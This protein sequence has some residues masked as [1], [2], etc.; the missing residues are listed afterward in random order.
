MKTVERQWCRSGVFI[1]IKYEHVLHFVLTVDFEQVNVCCV[2]LDF[3]F[4]FAWFVNTFL[5]QDQVHQDTTAQAF[6]LFK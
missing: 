1:V 4:D 6:H 5:Q 3:D 2:H